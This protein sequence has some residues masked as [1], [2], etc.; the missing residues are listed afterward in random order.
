MAVAGFS[1][2]KKEKSW[3][4]N[5]A[6]IVDID[7]TKYRHNGETKRDYNVTIDYTFNNNTYT[8][9]L[10]FYT[11]SM[12]IGDT[13][14]IYVNP[15]NPNE[16]VYKNG[17]ILFLLSGCVFIIIFPILGIKVMLNASKVGHITYIECTN[18]DDMISY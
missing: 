4:P 5:D 10:G 1:N 8:D 6:T 15:D 9:E 13:V 2:M 11:S 17:G 12:D 16:F 18:E 14:L 7:V 3:T